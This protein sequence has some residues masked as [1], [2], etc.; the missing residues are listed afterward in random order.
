MAV[1]LLVKL[2]LQHWHRGQSSGSLPAQVHTP[3]RLTLMLC[4]MLLQLLMLLGLP[5]VHV[6]GKLA[7]RLNAI[8]HVAS[9]AYALNVPHATG[10]RVPADRP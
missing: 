5:V 2:V 10:L 4:L 7:W 6:G 3:C 8:T 9:L 1:L